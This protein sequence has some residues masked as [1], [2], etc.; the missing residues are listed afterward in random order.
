MNGVVKIGLALILVGGGGYGAVRWYD[1]YQQRMAA[2]KW[3]ASYGTSEVIG[4]AKLRSVDT[5]ERV[6]QLELDHHRFSSLDDEQ[7]SVFFARNFCDRALRP[8]W[9]VEV[10]PPFKPRPSGVWQR[11]RYACVNLLTGPRQERIERMMDEA[12]RIIDDVMREGARQYPSTNPAHITEQYRAL[13]VKERARAA[14]Q[15]L[16][17]R[18]REA[19]Q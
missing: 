4:S 11:D 6:V 19:G 13:G 17:E 2:E 18:D 9:V 15:R 1:A 5:L 8:D 3:I 12:D 16:Q 14:E 7:A 10:A